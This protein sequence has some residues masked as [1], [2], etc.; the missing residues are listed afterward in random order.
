MIGDVKQ[1]PF[2][3]AMVDNMPAVQ[4]E[5]QSDF[6]FD[7]LDI[8]DDSVLDE[9]YSGLPPWWAGHNNNNLLHMNQIIV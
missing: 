2:L 5:S 3:S 6:S 1:M 7:D 8:S 9:M 4:D